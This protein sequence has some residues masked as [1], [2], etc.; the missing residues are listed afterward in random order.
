LRA[1]LG[2]HLFNVLVFPRLGTIQITGNARKT[3][4]IDIQN[5]LLNNLLSKL[6]LWICTTPGTQRPNQPKIFYRQQKPTRL[7]RSA[8]ARA[9]SS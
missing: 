7:P 2:F 8:Q 4:V 1:G 3:Q 5:I 6:G 9:A